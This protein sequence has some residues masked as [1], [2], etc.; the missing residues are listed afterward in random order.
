MTPRGGFAFGI[1]MCYALGMKRVRRFLRRPARERR[2]LL[3][4]V[5]WLLVMRLGLWLLP[6]RRLREIVSTYLARPRRPR[7]GSANAAEAARIAWA[8][9]A[10]GPYVPAT[11]CLTQALAA[12]VLLARA[13]H[14]VR[15]HIGVIREAGGQFAAHA[16]VESA[17]RVLIGGTEIESFTPLVAWSSEP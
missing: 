16:W 11:T 6:F 8:V 17:G 2:D 14:P 13:G 7:P 3:R 9:Q 4:A 10:V 1:G 12:Q 15:V 5:G